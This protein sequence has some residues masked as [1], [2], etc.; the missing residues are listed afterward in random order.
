[1]HTV[2]PLRLIC[3]AILFALIIN[4]SYSWVNVQL[5]RI[6]IYNWLVPGRLRFPYGDQI[7]MET[8]HSISVFGD[9]EAMF[10]S[11]IISGMSKPSAEYRV[12]LLGDS[13]VWGF[14][15]HASENLAA[16]INGLHLVTCDNRQVKAYDFGFP[17][18][19]SVR[20][21]LIIVRSNQYNPDLIVSFVTLDSFLNQEKNADWLTG[22]VNDLKAVASKYQLNASL[23]LPVAH[24]SIWDGTI[25]AN[26]KIIK[27][28]VL[29][30]INGLTWAGTSVDWYD[31]PFQA[32]RIQLP[33]SMALGTEYQSPR[34]K[35]QL[36]RALELDTIRVGKEEVGRSAFLVVNEPIQIYAGANSKLRYNVAYPRWA[37]DAYRT[38]LLKYTNNQKIS[39]L[40]LW[41]TLPVNAFS[42]DSSVHL[43]QR[44]EQ[45]V[46]ELLKAA[47][48]RS[49]CH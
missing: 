40:D 30:Q 5:G 31:S 45:L 25:W 26:R 1:M 6:S 33:H 28:V 11:H 22:H 9:F 36:L 23:D 21:L 48:L 20:D 3:K 17:E 7:N 10:G 8:V 46:A 4:F 27:K 12:I 43:S 13:S 18:A 15:V 19:S 41:N 34:D 39:Y 29:L 32:S 44:G 16:Q 35:S 42:S 37:Y 24:P 38:A 47:I 49:A 2:N 14:G